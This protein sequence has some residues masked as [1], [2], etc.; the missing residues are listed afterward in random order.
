VLRLRKLMLTLVLAAV[1]PAAA[2]ASLIFNLG[3]ASSSVM[4]LTYSGS[5]TTS[6]LTLDGSATNTSSFIT[7]NQGLI[8]KIGAV[9]NY[10]T[11]STSI[12]QTFGTLGQAVATSATGSAVRVSFASPNLIGLPSGYVSDSAIS[13]SMNF[14]GT[15]A[16]LGL[17][18][19]TYTFSWGVGGAGR[20]VTL[21]ISSTPIPEP[22]TM[23]VLA[24]G[25]ILGGYSYR[26]RVKR[27]GPRV[28]SN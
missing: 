19:G 20:T 8:R 12:G 17:T 4:T 28:A 13:G 23:G 7:P 16:S 9:D 21:N 14:N 25:S 15:L 1:A 3:P 26:R 10:D 27:S 5:I 6:D 24:I 2:D 18:S 22:A 11:A